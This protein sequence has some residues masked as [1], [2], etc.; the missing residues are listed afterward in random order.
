MAEFR[1]PSLGA[2]M[3]EGTLL[4]WRVHPGDVV[5]TGDIVAEVDTAKAAI[6]VECFA[7]GVIGEILVAEGT[8]VPVGSVLAT[9]EPNGVAKHAPA[10]HNSTT[11]RRG[12][13]VRAPA[14]GPA[15]SVTVS[16]PASGL[17]SASEPAPASAI[18]GSAAPPK[19]VRQRARRAPAEAA[20]VGQSVARA[21]P[22]A[23][24]SR[25]AAKSPTG[26][27]KSAAALAAAD[28][29]VHATPLIRRLAQEMGVDLATVKGSG[30]GGR[31]LRADVER[32]AAGDTVTGEVLGS[33]GTQSIS[34]SSRIPVGDRARASGYARRLA[35]EFG[36]ELSALRGTGPDGAIR[37]ADIR[38]AVTATA[39]ADNAVKTPVPH[40]VPPAPLESAPPAQ[41]DKTAM[42][43]AIA[44]S[45]TRSKQTIPHYYLSTTIDVG[46]ATDW[47][48]ELNRAAPV[49][50]R[51]IMAALLLKA[52]A[53]A[54]GAV[55]AVNGH[56]VDDGFRPA[57]TVDL[58]MIVSL[59]GG[60]I[61]APTLAHAG[62]M[63]LPELM[64]RLREAVTRARAARLRSTDTV[65][66]SITV[67]NLGELGVESVLGVI[68]PPQVAIVGF[69]AVT[70]RPCAVGGLLG[71]RPQVTTTLAADHRASDGAVGARFLNTIA[72][73]LQHPEQL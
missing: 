11:H 1:M 3:E 34:M 35:H 21:E 26:G 48:T 31:I 70:E 49:P 15:S 22:K 6:E 8:T 54:A 43:R 41:R 7:D 71:V 13:A 61:I 30:P 45:M 62:T 59:R 38:A 5:H 25:R 42:R 32:A 46:V 73:L 37:A 67:T 20:A 69:G 17:A 16:A 9:I 72:D 47:L 4:S 40:E 39:T 18:S 14:P 50:D 53:L 63:S 44:A 68:P 12:S 52:T 57:D 10:H 23:K 56:W 29:D 58:G 36:V 51:I 2:D 55:P 65:P 64:A 28:S 33:A 66:A 27:R 60:G 19:A 24:R